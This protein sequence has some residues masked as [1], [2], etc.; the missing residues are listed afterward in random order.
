VCG[1]DKNFVPEHVSYN[2][3]TSI[4]RGGWRRVLKILIKA[5]L[6]DRWRAQ[7]LFNTHLEYPTTAKPRLARVNH[8][9]RIHGIV[10]RARVE[11]RL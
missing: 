5:G 1:V 2:P 4:R 10:E 7:R 9:E 8:E 6:V 3:D 11:G